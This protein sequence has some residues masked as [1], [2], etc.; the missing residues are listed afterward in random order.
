MRLHRLLLLV[1]VA[2]FL[3]ACGADTGSAP[4][5]D[6]ELTAEYD[7]APIDEIVAGSLEVTGFEPT[8]GG[9]GTARLPVTTSQPVACSVVYGPTP[10]F[11][12]IS[13]DQDMAGGAH[14]EHSPLLTGLESNTTY[15]YRFQGADADGVVYLSEVMTFTTPDFAAQ[16]AEQPV[17]LASPEQGATVTGFSSAFGDADPNERWGI[18]NALDG[19]SG[20]EWSSAGDGDA[21]WLEVE[22]AQRAQ[23]DQIVFR[24]R[25]M[26]D[27]SGI[28]RAFTITTGDGQELGPF[29]L[30]DPD[31]GYTFDVDVE[32]QRLRFDLVDTTG[33]NTGIVDVAVYGE[34]LGG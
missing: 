21:A 27:G 32:A 12:A 31:S 17:N 15:H 1:L 26:S 33:G 20:T 24:S 7:F 28:T 8:G 11:G 22:L 6:N 23:I 3:T 14:S 4:A 30:P 16:A 2:G 34:F 13:T 18:M 10:A 19:N 5:P 9:Q 29:E 25:A